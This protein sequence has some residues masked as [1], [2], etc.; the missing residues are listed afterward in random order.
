MA[1]CKIR[2]FRERHTGLLGILQLEQDVSNLFGT[3]HARQAIGAEHQRIPTA[4]IGVR[5]VDL[6]RIRRA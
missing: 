1:A 2:A 6:D 3:D 4:K 5:E